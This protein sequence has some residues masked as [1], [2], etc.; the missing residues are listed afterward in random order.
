MHKKPSYRNKLISCSSAS[1][2]ETSTELAKLTKPAPT[3]NIRPADPDQTLQDIFKCIDPND[4]STPMVSPENGA[5]S[6][7][8]NENLASNP[9]PQTIQSK[10]APITLKIKRNFH[11]TK[12]KQTKMQQLPNVSRNPPQIYQN[13][14]YGQSQTNQMA[15]APPRH[16]PNAQ[17]NKYIPNGQINQTGQIV[18]AQP[19]PVPNPIATAGHFC[20]PFDAGIP[21]NPNPDNIN[22]PAGVPTTFLQL[23]YFGKIEY[24]QYPFNA[25]LNTTENKP[26]CFFPYPENLADLDFQKDNEIS[27]KSDFIL[28]LFDFILQ[29]ILLKQ[30]P[31]ETFKRCA[32][33]QIELYKVLTY[34]EELKECLKN[35]TENDVYACV[36]KIEKKLALIKMF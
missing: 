12:P 4:T 9:S 18:V 35:R 20:W 22:A 6:E 23:P 10:P 8:K 27:Q 5:G 17:N 16:R 24:K 32:A 13:V 7:V 2:V 11:P 31:L 15:T 19:N 28:R 21:N 29:G 25:Y 1:S 30:H 33:N 26:F 3:C 34:V 14:A 36:D